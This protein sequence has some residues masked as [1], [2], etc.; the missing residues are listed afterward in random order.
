MKYSADV[1]SSRRKS[2]RDYFTAGSEARRTLM[3]ASLS[4]ELRKQFGVRSLPIRKEDKVK[5]VRGENKDSEG[6]V[7]VVYRKKFI[8]NIERVQQEKANGAPVPVGIHPSKVVITEVKMDKDRKN[9]IERKA[10]GRRAYK[11]DLASMDE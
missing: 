8:I 10:K 6:K 11:K 4:K 3:S 7:T 5:V 2:R 1:S 9:L